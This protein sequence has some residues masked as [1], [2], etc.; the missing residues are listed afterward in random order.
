[1]NKKLKES[2]AICIKNGYKYKTVKE[3]LAIYTPVGWKRKSIDWQLPDRIS[4]IADG[5]T[6]FEELKNR[7]GECYSGFLCLFKNKGR[8]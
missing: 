8:K 3:M 2:V 4:A 1:M 7:Y 5:V 6:Y